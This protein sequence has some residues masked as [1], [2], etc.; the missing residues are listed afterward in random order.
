MKI[1]TLRCDVLY[2]HKCT[3]VIIINKLMRFLFNSIICNYTL[4]ARFFLEYLGTK[5]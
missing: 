4:I 1:I 3:L 2:L 5:L